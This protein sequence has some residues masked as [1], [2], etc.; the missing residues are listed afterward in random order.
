LKIA[1]FSVYRDGTGY[2]QAAFD[3]I[4]AIEKAGYDIVCR[5]IRMSNPK[6]KEKCLV[7]HLEKGNLKNVDIIIQHNLPQ[8]FEKGT[9]IKT[10]GIFDWET[11][12]VCQT[13]VD[14][15]N[16]LDEIWVPN[17]QQKYA[18][19][20]SGIKVPPHS[21]IVGNSIKILPHS[22]NLR[23][24]ENRPKS[25]DIAL[26]KDKCIFYFIGENT[27]RK[28][29]AALIRAYYVAFT[30]KENIILIIKTSSPGHNSQQTMQM[31]QKFILDIK[32]A[33]HIYADEKNY[34]PI[35]VLTEHLS[36]EQ[37][38]QLH[39]SSNIFVSPSHGEGGN[40]EA[41]DAMGWGNPVILSNWGFHPELCYGQAEKY[42]IPDKEIFKH[43]GE[44]DCGFL[45]PGQLTYCF[46]QLNASGECYTGKELWFDVCMPSFVSILKKAY[47]EYKDRS[48]EKRKIAAKERIQKF[49]YENTGN[50]LKELLND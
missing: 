42:W 33:I 10:I 28:N 29:I 44:V 45:I 3:N 38:A 37:L 17:I 5:P 20:K 4:L 43:P 23:K 16:K 26:L 11:N 14:S 13:W 41:M 2:G 39:V 48:L 40:L 18:C 12:I 30:E 49:S 6:I 36:E 47:I 7:E 9:G 32:K 50:I 1:Y 35:L 46:G 19:L 31:M 15:C 27:R 24:Y 21:S 8:T 34:P 25:L 22:V